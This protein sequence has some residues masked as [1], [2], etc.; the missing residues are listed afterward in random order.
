MTTGGSVRR[1]LTTTTSPLWS[2]VIGHGHGE[3]EGESEGAKPTRA[4]AA[5]CLARTN[6]PP[7]S[8]AQRMPL[9]VAG[10]GAEGVEGLAPRRSLRS[11]V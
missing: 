7:D 2:L 6:Q 11:K 4:R 3:N 9:G 1:S 10:A 5:A 8:D